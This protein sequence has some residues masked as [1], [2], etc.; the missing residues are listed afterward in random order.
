[1]MNPLTTGRSSRCCILNFDRRRKLRQRSWSSSNRSGGAATFRPT[2]GP[3]E[4]RKA[5][6]ALATHYCFSRCKLQDIPAGL[7]KWDELVRR[8]ER[9]KSSGT[10]TVGL[11]EDIKTAALE[12][13][14][15]RRVG[16]ASCHAPC[17]IDHVRAGSKR[18][19]GLHLTPVEVSSCSGREL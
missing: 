5:Q 7:E 3:S 2:W 6:S 10:M 12:N 18:N 4:W 1:M 9:S 14:R 8:Y 13:P 15:P 17:R 16:A 11:D 19:S